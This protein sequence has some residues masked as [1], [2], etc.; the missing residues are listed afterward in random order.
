MLASL[1]RP[2]WHESCKRGPKETANLKKK[3]FGGTISDVAD[4]DRPAIARVGLGEGDACTAELGGGLSRMTMER[5]NS[6]YG[7]W[8]PINMH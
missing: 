1:F 4:V 6:A 3:C 2:S 7:P 8:N 5:F